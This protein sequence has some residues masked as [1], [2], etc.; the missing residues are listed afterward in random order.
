MAAQA[1]ECTVA[2][3][4]RLEEGFAGGAEAAPDAVR[5]VRSFDCVAVLRR[6]G[7]LKG[8]WVADGRDGNKTIGAV[9]VTQLFKT[10]L[11]SRDWAGRCGLP[12]LHIRT[13]SG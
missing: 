10:T 11:C 12:E 4:P 6:A 1:D 5:E 2:E 3:V 8:L 9:V 7:C 13:W